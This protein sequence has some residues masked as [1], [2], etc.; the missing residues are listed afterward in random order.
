MKIAFAVLTMSLISVSASLAAGT[1]GMDHMTMMGNMDMAE[2]TNMAEHERGTAFYG[3]YSMRREASGTS[4]Q[5]EA[6]PME[7]C[8][9][10]PHDWLI[11][12]HGFAFG[13]YDYQGGP[14]GDKKFVSPNMFMGMAEHPLGPGTFGMRA[15]LSLE[16]ATIGKSGYP[17]LLQTGETADGVHPLIDRQHP[18]DLFMELAATYSIPVGNGKS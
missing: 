17:L 14:R 2:H 9:I 11:M 7:G 18:H 6:T 4:W 12:L 5:P 1:N 3:D 13:V 15:M 16:P 8:H 10:Y